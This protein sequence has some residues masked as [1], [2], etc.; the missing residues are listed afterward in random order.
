MKGKMI[1][2]IVFLFIGFIIAG[3][4]KSEEHDKI[5]MEETGREID[6]S[7]VRN[8][9]VEVTSLDENGDGKVYQCPM[10]SQVISDEA[11]I[12]PLCK[13]EL[14]EYS[15]AEAQNNFETKHKN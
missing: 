12:C 8:L 7:I 4:G 9:G 2:F 11:D 5:E 6:S 14:E 1:A 13:M 10:H 3:C 15:V